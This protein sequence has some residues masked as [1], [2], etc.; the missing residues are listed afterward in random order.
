MIVNSWTFWKHF[1]NIW[2]FI[3]LLSV[4]D[5]ALKDAKQN[6]FRRLVTYEP[7]AYKKRCVLLS[8]VFITKWKKYKKILFHLFKSVDIFDNAKT[9]SGLD[10]RSFWLA[11][12]ALS[13][14]SDNIY[15]NL[16]LV[17]EILCTVSVNVTHFSSVESWKLNDNH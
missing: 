7:V 12:L 4:G 17:F 2:N 5:S 8:R 1:L 6:T 10:W 9:T 3:L 15:S 16:F 14:R 11:L 13:A